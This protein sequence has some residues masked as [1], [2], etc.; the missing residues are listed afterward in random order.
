MKRSRTVP[1]AARVCA[2][3][4]SIVAAACT[5]RQPAASAVVSSCEQEMKD[6][7]LRS[8]GR[9]ADLSQWENPAGMHE[10]AGSTREERIL[11]WSAFQRDFTIDA[12]RTIGADSDGEGRRVIGYSGAVRGGNADAVMLLRWPSG[13]WS[14]EIRIGRQD[15]VIRARCTDRAASA[16]DRRS[17]VFLVDR[18][19]H[20]QA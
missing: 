17:V 6:L 11:H 1:H 19:D 10:V 4:V 16:T 18:P 12:Y 3:A 7:D 13:A 15:Y 14:G 9:K 8:H 5:A 2:A 20:P